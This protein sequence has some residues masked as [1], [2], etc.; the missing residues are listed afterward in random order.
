[1]IPLLLQ[2]P[3]EAGR[4]FLVVGSIAALVRRGPVAPSKY[5]NSKIAEMRVVEHVA[6]QFGER[7]LFAAVVHLGAVATEMA[8]G[9]SSDEDFKRCMASL[10]NLPSLHVL[11]WTRV[12]T[13]G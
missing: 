6:E 1:M 3:E 9:A 10:S 7:S 4:A 12:L 2:A 11:T 8:F 5:C 13:R